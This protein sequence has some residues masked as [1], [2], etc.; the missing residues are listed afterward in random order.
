MNIHLRDNLLATGPHLIVRKPSDE[1][2]NSAGTGSTLQDDND[3]LVAV[4]ASD[5]WQFVFNIIYSSNTTADFK[6]AFTQPAG[7]KISGSGV[8]FSP[9][10]ATIMSN[11]NGDTGSPT[12]SN[13]LGGAALATPILHR[14]DGIWTGGGTAGNVRL[15]WAQNT[16]DAGNTVVHANS[17]LWAV[18][19]V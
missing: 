5:I 14:F 16:S 2:V 17:T 7:G 6:F 10:L 12:S 15:Q 8:A 9:V 4:G 19:L 3:L 18:K 11:L 1:T 13:A